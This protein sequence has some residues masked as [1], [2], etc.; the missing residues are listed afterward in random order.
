MSQ[1]EAHHQ[2]L[3][4]PGAGGFDGLSPLLQGENMPFRR[5]TELYTLP[6]KLCTHE[7]YTVLYTE[8]CTR[9]QVGTRSRFA[10]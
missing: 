3:D 1:G 9:C 4:V 10:R 7:L 8:L 6:G 5:L 2:G